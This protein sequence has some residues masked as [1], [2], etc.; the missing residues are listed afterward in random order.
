MVFSKCIDHKYICL[1]TLKLERIF[2]NLLQNII[3]SKHNINMRRKPLSIIEIKEKVSLAGFLSSYISLKKR[4]ILHWGLCPFHSERSPSFVVNSEKMFFHCFGCG[5]HG[6][7]FSFLQKYKNFSFTEAVTEICD[8]Y[9]LEA[10]IFQDSNKYSKNIKEILKEIADIFHNNLKENES[11][12]LENRNVSPNA[13]QEFNIG[14]ATSNCLKKIIESG[15]SL[16]FLRDIGLVGTYGNLL[17]NNR[18]IFP[19]QNIQG[20]TIGFSGRSIDNNTTPKYINSKENYIFSKSCSLFNI[21][22][23]ISSKKKTVI[24]VEGF[25]D[26]ISM[27]QK[28]F[29]NV[30]GSMGTSITSEQMFYLANK[31]EE[32]IS[33][34]DGDI[35]GYKASISFAEI[36]LGL[37]SKNTKFFIA[38]LP[39][40]TDPDSLIQSLGIDP[41]YDAI[42]KKKHVLDFLWDIVEESTE[43]NIADIITLRKKI[44]EIC[45]K[46]NDSEIRKLAQELLENK[47]N[48]KKAILN[49]RNIKPSIP[50]NYQFSTEVVLIGILLNYPELAEQYMEQ[51]ISYEY[52]NTSVKN[53][54][55]K[56][57]NTFQTPWTPEE[58][59]SNLQS[60]SINLNSFNQNPMVQ[61]L[62]K[63][64][65]LCHQ[66]VAD[67]L[68]NNLN[69]VEKSLGAK[70]I[71]I[72]IPDFSKNK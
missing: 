57:I 3:Y 32:I 40:N 35:A 55:E 24:L 21:D 59:K 62:G 38:L 9:N 39:Q 16:N 60:Q 19:I 10:P 7:I 56:I 26:V 58:L 29:D 64:Y 14:L 53:I 72:K 30:V 48:K 25:F 51:L 69:T 70:K 31:F 52:K 49:Y 23:A 54:I 5:E 43:N 34:M 33:I 42:K 67:F 20:N 46:I 41:I 27:H 6:D 47:L 4:G 63:S 18:I 15:V 12:L 71:N 1:L 45:K 36:S 65:D 44:A 66:F 37:L 50:N 68:R 8:K 22:K 2:I 61:T 11:T 28:G 17:F 13:I